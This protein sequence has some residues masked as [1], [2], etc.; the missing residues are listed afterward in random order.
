MSHF[1]LY[2]SNCPKPGHEPPSATAGAAGGARTGEGGAPSAMAPPRHEVPP[3]GAWWQSEL[4]EFGGTWGHD[5]NCTSWDASQGADGTAGR[6]SDSPGNDDMA[7]RTRHAR[8][9]ARRG[10]GRPPRVARRR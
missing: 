1:P 10:V 7:R 6:R 4:C 8:R 2:C 3:P 9:L 5:R